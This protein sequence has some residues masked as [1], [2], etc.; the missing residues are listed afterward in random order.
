[1]AITYFEVL[2]NIAVLIII[3]FTALSYATGLFYLAE[4]AEEF[5]TLTGRLIRFLIAAICVLHVLAAVLSPLSKLSLLLGLLAHASYYHLMSSFPNL[6]LASPAF[7]LSLALLLA[8]QVSWYLT[9]SSDSASPPPSAYGYG[10]YGSSYTTRSY[11]S[12]SPPQLLAFYFLFVWLLPLVFFIAGSVS[13]QSLPSSGE[14]MRGGDDDSSGKS[15]KHSRWSCA[16][17]ARWCRSDKTSR[18]SDG[19]NG[20]TPS[21]SPSPSASPSSAPYMS[22]PYQPN[23]GW[24][25]QPSGYGAAAGN[26]GQWMGGGQLPPQHP[27]QQPM[28]SLPQP[29]YVRQRSHHN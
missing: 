2:C 24:Y 3:V 1:M 14:R 26:E 10:S 20:P 9:L 16:G 11:P 15:K 27:A 6:Q 19:T 13:G 22:P 4:L 7:F 5:P 12:Y 29:M 8:S 18:D 28:M 25:G 23:A 21:H 17:I